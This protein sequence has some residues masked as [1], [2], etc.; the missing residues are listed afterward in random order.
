[1]SDCDPIVGRQWNFTNVDL[2][3]AF[4]KRKVCTPNPSIIRNERGSVR[5][6]I[7]HISMCMLSGI[8]LAKSQKVSCA[9]AAWGKPRSG[10]IF[11][12]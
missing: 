11:T 3:V 5:S 10:S 4:T 2:P 8:R 9:L 6:D 12:A 7:A 1:M